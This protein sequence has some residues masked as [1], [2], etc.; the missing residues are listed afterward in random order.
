MEHFEQTSESQIQNFNGSSHSVVVYGTST[1]VGIGEFPYG[2]TLSM[3]LQ[4][5]D[6]ISTASPSWPYAPPLDLTLHS[7]RASGQ[8]SLELNAAQDFADGTSYFAVG[9]QGTPYLITATDLIPF[10]DLPARGIKLKSSKVSLSRFSHDG[11]LAYSEGRATVD[12]LKLY[13]DISSYASEHIFF[14]DPESLVV[15]VLYA[16]GT[17]FHCLYPSIGY[18]HL[19][20][21]KASG[22]TRCL[23]LLAPIVFNGEVSVSLHPQVLC[24]SINTNRSTLLWDEAQSVGRGGGK[25]YSDT[26]NILKSGIYP[27]GQIVLPERGTPTTYSTFG[28]KIFAGTGHLDPELADRTIEIPMMRNLSS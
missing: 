18:L 13:T 6:N 26:V 20:G 22:K 24:H 15:V 12:P 9:I 14:K 1:A 8:G 28:P 5:S 19:R 10:D 3:S 7:A 21:E 25:R 4:V 23:S 17:Y 27:D 2:T 16:I 11:I